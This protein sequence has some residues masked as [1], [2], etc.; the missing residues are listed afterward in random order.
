MTT[1]IPL[2][3]TKPDIESLWDE[4][5]EAIQGVLKSGRFIMGPNVKAFEDE[6]AAYLDVKHAIAVNSGTDA[7][8]LA[9]KAMGIGTGDEVIT[10]AFTFFA[11]TEAPSHFGAV[12][13]F[14]DIDPQT[15]NLDVTQIEAQI[16]PRTKA[17]LPVHLYGQP[18]DMD[19]I[20]A[21]AQ[22]YNLRV[23]EDVA[24]AFGGNYKG[25]KLAAIGDAGALSFFPSKNLGAFGDGGML[26]TN[27][28][29]IA[30]TVKMLRVHGARK[31][32]YNEVVG[33]NS[34]L[35]ELQAAILR[36]K[37]KTL[38]QANEKRR[39]V[40][41]RYNRLLSEVPGVTTPAETPYGTHV[42]HQYTIRIAGGRRDHVKERL[43]EQGIETMIYYP[44]P[45]HQLKPYA[46]LGYRLP[47]TEQACQEV[48]SL[49]LWHQMEPETQL[50]V[51]EALA[52]IL[53][54]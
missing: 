49:P 47:L 28:D 41:H 25:R 22:K 2:L 19:P 34:R 37:F 5:M 3:D 32:Y 12:P 27:D 1:K 7:L 43:A 39:Q 20:L 21:L 17:I 8:V 52:G 26:V 9:A 30:E 45:L 29:T 13:V 11:T 53:K 44:I 54:T 50:R 16:T 10:T 36:V 48:L 31:K 42:F 38:N 4:L 15:F 51:V 18:A 14:V 46:H 35:D 23:L 33:Y 40:A 6:V 24:Q